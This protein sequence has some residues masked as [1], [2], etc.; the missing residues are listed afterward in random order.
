M[1]VDSVMSS[2][3][4][5]RDFVTGENKLDTDGERS[6]LGKKDI[7]NL[8]EGDKVI[9]QVKNDPI[10]FKGPKL[11]TNLALISPTVILKTGENSVK[12]SRR[13]NCDETR[14]HLKRMLDGIA[15]SDE[16][17]IVRTAAAKASEQVVKSDISMLRKEHLEIL[18]KS[19]KGSK[20]I[21][22]LHC[23]GSV[24]RVFRSM[25]FF[26]HTMLSSSESQY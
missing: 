23:L 26:S 4:A 13:I 18:E 17:F 21:K 3:S 24:E 7:S 10:E 19:Q 14:F 11:T 8:C 12:I 16:G 22:L 25:S 1:V 2:L 15:N 5:I 6:T 20:P 9:V